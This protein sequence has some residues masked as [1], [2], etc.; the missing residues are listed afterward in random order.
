VSRK[1]LVL[2]IYVFQ[3]P[4]PRLTPRSTLKSSTPR[5]WGRAATNK[6]AAFASQGT[7]RHGLG[8]H[9]GS[10]PSQPPSS[11]A[12]PTRPESHTATQAS[13]DATKPIAKW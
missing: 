13:G 3:P 4:L 10:V 5:R 7:G 8:Q 1:A 9:D 6:M 2:L 12:F 11:R